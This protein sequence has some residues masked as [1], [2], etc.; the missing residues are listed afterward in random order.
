MNRK[1][2]LAD[3]LCAAGITGVIAG[4]SML[5]PALILL[6]AGGASCY[7]GVYL[8]RQAISSDSGRDEG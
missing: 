4:L 5:N 8:H 7:A 3:G 6:V 2:T 1:L